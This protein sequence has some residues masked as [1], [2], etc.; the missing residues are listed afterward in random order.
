MNSLLVLLL[1]FSISSAAQEVAG[2]NVVPT[3]AAESPAPAVATGKSHVQIRKGI[4]IGALDA[5]GSAVSSLTKDELQVMDSG[6]AATPLM[7]RKADALPLDLGIVLYAGT[8]NFSQQQA[9]AIDLV[10]KIIRPDMDHAF[11]IAA[12]GNRAWSEGNLKWE[13]D[14]L[15]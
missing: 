7:V 1:S 9:A 11:V 6:Q 14:V 15:V 10:K 4:L 5:S 3:P 12:G 8:G 2:G 13:N